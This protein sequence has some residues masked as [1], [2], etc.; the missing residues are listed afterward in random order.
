MT[1]TADPVT[2]L[3]ATPPTKIAADVVTIGVGVVDTGAVVGE[4][5]LGMTGGGVVSCAIAEV[6][7]LIAASEAHFVHDS[8][9]TPG[10]VTTNVSPP[11]VIDVGT[12]AQEVVKTTTGMV[13]TEGVHVKT[14]TQGVWIV[15]V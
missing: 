10:V 2:C 8:V 7:N 11:V 5:V 15:Q 1:L 9:Q 3:L 6:N 13:T 4:L 12:V 14:V